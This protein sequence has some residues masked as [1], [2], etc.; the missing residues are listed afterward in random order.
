MRF[1]RSYGPIPNDLNLFDEY[2]TGALGRAS[3]TDGGSCAG[4]GVR[5]RYGLDDPVDAG[6]GATGADGDETA[7]TASG[8]ST[9]G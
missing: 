7:G 1:L 3:A 9:G 4:S 8:G 5:D 6:S 2:V